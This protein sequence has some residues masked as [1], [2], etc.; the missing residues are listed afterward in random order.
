MEYNIMR[1]SNDA[2]LR[3]CLRA[4]DGLEVGVKVEGFDEKKCS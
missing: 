2:Q 4:S 1:K 3:I